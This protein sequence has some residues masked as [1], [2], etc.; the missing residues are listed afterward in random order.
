MELRLRT[1]QPILLLNWTTKSKNLFVFRKCTLSFQYLNYSASNKL[2][3]IDLNFAYLHRI[4]RYFCELNTFFN[5]QL[6]AL[7]AD[8]ILMVAQYLISQTMVSFLSVVL[9]IANMWSSH[10]LKNVI[11]FI[12]FKLA[13]SFN[14]P[15]RKPKLFILM[16]IRI[17]LQ[18]FQLKI[19]SD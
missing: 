5:V 14:S 10:A 3:S 19:R 9:S 4:S 17:I 12:E 18:H 11:G 13:V 15:R 8:W 6:D 2:F 7:A 1:P 16:C